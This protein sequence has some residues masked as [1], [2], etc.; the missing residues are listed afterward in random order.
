MEDKANQN[1]SNKKSKLESIKNHFSGTVEEQLNDNIPSADIA[2]SI[3]LLVVNG[4]LG[5]YFIA[6]QT[7]ST[8]FFTSK[9]S[10][11]EMVMLYGILI[12]W[13]T[14]SVLIL[15]GQK[16]PSRDLDSFGGLFFAT[17]AI[18]WLFFVFP[19]NFTHYA[20]VWQPEFLKFLVQ[21][22]SNGIARVILV[23]L[24]TVHLVFAIYALIQRLYVRKARAQ[25]KLGEKNE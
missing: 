4:S 14:T 22:I 16:N 2:A 23:L 11:F 8:R 24:F 15:L 25:R 17:F 7:S 1:D 9:F 12:Y 19:F 18:A 5:L 13:I 6:H 10:R 21:W 3:F 20:D